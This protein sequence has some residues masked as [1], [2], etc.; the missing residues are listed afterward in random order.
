[1]LLA[2]VAET[3]ELVAG[4]ASRS[5]K[6]GLVADLLRRASPGDVPVLVA[7]LSGAAGCAA[8]LA[9]GRAGLAR[10]RLRPGQ[11]LRPMLA[12][13]AGSASDA[14][15]VDGDDLVAE[16]AERFLATA[17]ARGHEGV[18]AKSLSMPYALGRE[19]PAG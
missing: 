3:S 17:V 19:A 5:A 6:V 15:H 1:M 2:A 8:V 18:V 11:P 13:S 10:F 16:E 7:Y 14:L 9:E 4:T 12:Q